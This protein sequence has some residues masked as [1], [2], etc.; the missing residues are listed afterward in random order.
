[1]REHADPHYPTGGRMPG[2]A[3]ESPMPVVHVM[4]TDI[5]DIALISGADSED[6]ALQSRAE[7]F[8]EGQRS[9]ARTIWTSSQR[10]TCRTAQP[11]THPEKAGQ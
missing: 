7:E 10:I 9:G 2:L 5:A 6:E 1:M 8:L 3:A 4:A 11:I